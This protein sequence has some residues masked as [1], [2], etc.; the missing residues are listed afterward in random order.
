MKSNFD[1][2]FSK[3]VF[4][5][6]LPF[7][8]LFV[9]ALFY[10]AMISGVK[11]STYLALSLVCLPVVCFGLVLYDSRRFW[12][13]RRGVALAIFLMYANFAYLQIHSARNFLSMNVLDAG[14]GF[15]LAGLPALVYFFRG[16][17]TVH[18]SLLLWTRLLSPLAAISI[19]W[20]RKQQPRKP[21][22]LP[23]RE[24]TKWYQQ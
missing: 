20:K 15:L 22:N 2:P 5:L 8:L 7:L 21:R 14:A 6:A 9:A 13:A 18:Q 1:E 4:W 12:W 11:A 24:K 16:I 3:T 23:T 19:G 17:V 10:F